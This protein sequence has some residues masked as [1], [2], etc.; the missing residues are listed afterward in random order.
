MRSECIEIGNV[1]SLVSNKLSLW[2][3]DLII[4]LQKLYSN[5]I[6]DTDKREH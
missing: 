2:L 5:T 4:K 1:K 3:S 6:N